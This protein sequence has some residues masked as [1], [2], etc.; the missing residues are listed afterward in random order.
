MYLFIILHEHAIKLHHSV[1]VFYDLLYFPS[2]YPS[3]II[4]K[5]LSVETAA[6]LANPMIS[7]RIDYCNSLLY[8]V[9]KYT[10]AKLQK[11]QNALYR[12]VFRF[13]KTSHVTP[14]LQKLHWIPISYRILFKYNLIT[15]KA[16]KF[17]QPKYLPSLIKFRTL[18][19]GFWLSLSS[20]HPKKA[21]GR[22]GFAVASP[23]ECNRLP[24]SV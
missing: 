2:R 9:N 20:F 3:S 5:F 6:L 7:S 18:T 10:L 4:R 23:T 8:G 11:I 16:I 12:I 15:F 22:R 24:Q 19:H 13:D 14:Y 17:S 1:Y 21:I